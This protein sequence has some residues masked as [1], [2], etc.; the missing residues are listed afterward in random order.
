MSSYVGIPTGNPTKYLGP[1]V[2]ILS[3]VNRD[4]SPTGADIRQGTTGTY[5][6]VGSFWIVSKAPT[7]GTEGDLWWLSKIVAN[8][9]YWVQVGNFASPLTIDGDTGAATGNPILLHALNGSIGSTNCGAS[10]LFTASGNEI[11]LTVTDANG[12]TFIGFDSGVNVSISGS[13]NTALGTFALASIINFNAQ[14]NVAIGAG[15]LFSLQTGANNVCIGSPSCASNVDGVGNC[16]VGART[17]ENATTGSF[18]TCIGNGAGQGVVSGSS[19]IFIGDGSGQGYAGAEDSNIL[20]A[21][22]GVLGE[23]NVTRIGT[24]GNTSGE[25][26]S[27]F[28]A[29]IVGVTVANTQMVTIDST[30]GQLGIIPLIVSDSFNKIVVQT[31]TSNGTYTP[32]TGMKY[33]MIEIVGGGGGSGGSGTAGPDEVSSSAGGGGGGYA[34]KTVTSATIG[35][36]QVV[37]IG[38]GGTAGAAGAGTGGT[39]GTTSVGAIVTATGGTGGL[40]GA[41]ATPGLLYTNPGTAGGVGS[42]GDININGSPGG[43]SIAIGTG[44]NALSGFGGSS[45]FG[46]GAHSVQQG[47]TAIAGLS[48]GGGAAGGAN[49]INTGQIAGAAGADGVVIITEYISI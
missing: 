39:G 32:T 45:Y 13:N 46:G 30:S 21:N 33:C 42:S 49:N 18:N 22:Q 37:T 38:A 20:I 28:I 44:T 29:G 43:G 11:D 19:N 12:N 17:L 10:V 23:S 36:S 15:A 3:I 31:F 5:Y 7:T 6:P 9:A 1:G 41:V 35:V 40:F 16:C 27:C 2:A 25:V 47:H 26:N 24:Q 48:Y 4:R 34:R 14:S 8:V